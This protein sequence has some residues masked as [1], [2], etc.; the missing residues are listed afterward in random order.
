MRCEPSYQSMIEVLAAQAAEQGDA[1]AYTY[2]DER[3][4]ESQITYA[5]LDRR[6]R[7]IAARLQ[8]ELSP[9]DRALLVYPAGLEFICAFFGCLYAGVI[10]VPA[11]YPKPKRPMPRLQRIAVDCDAHVA[12]STAQTLTTLDPELLSADAATNQWIAT[13]EL[14]NDLAD[15]WH[16]PTVDKSDLAFLQYTSGS[17]SDP[18]GVMVSHANLLANLERIRQ[19]F[20]IGDLEEDVASSTGV[21]WLPAYHDMGLIGGILTAMYMGGR[22]VLMSPTAFLQRPMRWLQAISDYNGII[23]GA[24]N[25][26]YEY[27]VRRISAEERATLDLS[28]WRLAFCG[29]EP[30]RSETLVHFAEAFECA[31]FRLRS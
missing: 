27:C 29:A 3:D 8:L 10:A 17:T 14:N 13:D 23:S 30:I 26:A 16:R 21:S 19:S 4:G 18:K 24:P 15:L 28:G 22:I 5:E 25:F 11:T 2:L 6:A 12:L 9:G 1:T 31:G 20:G 7:V